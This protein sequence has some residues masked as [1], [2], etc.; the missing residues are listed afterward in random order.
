MK[1]ATFKLLR[2]AVEAINDLFNRRTNDLRLLKINKEKALG[3]LVLDAVGAT[4]LPLPE[5]EKL[6]KR[7]GTR[8]K[9]AAKEA[10]RVARLNADHLRA[11]RQREA[12]ASEITAIEAEH[13]ASLAAIDATEYCL[14]VELAL[15]P[16]TVQEEEQQ[17]Q[18]TTVEL[19][20]AALD[21]ATERHQNTMDELIEA[22]QD[23]ATCLELQVNALTEVLSVRKSQLARADL[24]IGKLEDA[25]DE[26]RDEV[27]ELKLSLVWERGRRERAEEALLLAGPSV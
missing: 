25:L 22:Q 9:E 16:P 19:I 26:S 27:E 21:R 10:A 7:V 2:L 18:P 1:K 3:S 24:R 15:E 8:V 6:G 23:V 5:A 12:S 11:A 20:R 17:E 4:L 13:E 14:G